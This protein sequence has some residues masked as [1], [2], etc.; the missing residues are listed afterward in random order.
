IAELDIEVNPHYSFTLLVAHLKSR[1]P[2]AEA[3]EAELREQEALVLREKVDALLRSNPSAN[4]VVAGDLNDVK[5]A[6]STRAVLGK[7]KNALVDTRPAE[8]NGDRE[9]DRNSSRTVPRNVTWTH[10]F[11]KEDVYSRIDFIL[12]SRGMAREWDPSG[13]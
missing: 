6:T 4:I 10:F 5:D 1:R 13:S 7:G 8:R 11:A 2:A 3:D 9:A 12:V